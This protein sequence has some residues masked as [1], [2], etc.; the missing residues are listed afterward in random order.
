MKNNQKGLHTRRMRLSVMVV[1]ICSAVVAVATPCIQI[2]KPSHDFGEVA[3]NVTVNWSC[4][5]SNVGDRV[6][7]IM[8]VRACCGASV[9]EF[10]SVLQSGTG[11]V[12]RVDLNPGA[13][14]GPFRKTVT[15]FSDDPKHPVSIV[16]LSGR[17]RDYVPPTSTNNL[18][19]P[20]PARQP[21]TSQQPIAAAKPL[22][23]KPRH[24]STVHGILFPE[25]I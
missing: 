13:Q 6:L 16:T 4:A 20:S 9:G 11:A 25:T 8:S 19:P 23:G 5:V 17:I 2:E 3:P 22:N 7:S 1:V 21:A 15:V 14:P 24:S 18:P 10:P 12:L